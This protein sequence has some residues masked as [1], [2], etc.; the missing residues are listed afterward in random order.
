MCVERPNDKSSSSLN[1]IV[2]LIQSLEFLGLLQ[3]KI[4]HAC[5]ELVRSPASDRPSG[6]S[7][8]ASGTLICDI[9]S[10]SASSSGR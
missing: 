6:G 5:V 8:V 1:F 3:I 7:G 9:Y 10:L 2:L 4:C